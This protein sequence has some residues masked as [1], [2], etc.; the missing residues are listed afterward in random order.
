M[1][2]AK[3]ALAHVEYLELSGGGKNAVRQL[4]CLQRLYY[5]HP[6][7]FQQLRGI[8]GTSA[9]AM[10]GA[11]LIMT[12]FDICLSCEEILTL[13]LEKYGLA[14]TFERMH[15][16]LFRGGLNTVASMAPVLLDPLL[17][18]YCD[19]VDITL[20]DFCKKFNIDFRPRA[21]D[22]VTGE[23]VTLPS[24]MPLRLALWAAGAVPFVNEPIAWRSSLFV[25]GGLVLNFTLDAFASPKTTF[26]L[27]VQN[28]WTYL[29]G[30][31]SAIL[32][33]AARTRQKLDAPLDHWIR[34]AEINLCLGINVFMSLLKGLED[35][36]TPPWT[37]HVRLNVRDGSSF[38][39]MSDL[40]CAALLQD[41]RESMDVWITACEIQW[42]FTA[43]CVATLH[44]Q[45]H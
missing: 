30:I 39:D 2:K 25:D 19:D 12:K 34:A 24:D 15:S 36:R 5:F 3:D 14:P 38:L 26:G 33:A 4:G 16:F 8:S 28:E 22:V 35:A 40:N 20:G 45:H 44:K 6:T 1:F 21:V 17:R 37:H 43:L 42:F 7:F 31:N 32:A 10:I 18:R 13:P 41:G 27:R 9:G 11:L 23:V 29:T